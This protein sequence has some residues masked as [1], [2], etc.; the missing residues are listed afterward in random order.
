MMQHLKRRPKRYLEDQNNQ[1]QVQDSRV[2]TKRAQG[3]RLKNTRKGSQPAHWWRTGL[4][5]VH[6]TSCAESSAN[7]LSEAG[8]PKCPV[9][10]RQYGQRPATAL[11]TVDDSSSNGRLAWL[12]HRTCPDC[13]VH[14]MIE[15]TSFYPT[16]LF[17]G[18]YLYPLQPATS[19]V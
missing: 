5:D 10:T 16:I 2:K 11:P 1:A 13:L 6:R 7:G 19:G 12:R 9:C 15:T 18:G 17:E 3:K 14:P 8:A 4:S